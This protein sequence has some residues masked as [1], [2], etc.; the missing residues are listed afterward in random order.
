M[1][2]LIDEVARQLLLLDA[3]EA[4]YPLHLA[5]NVGDRGI[6]LD[7]QQLQKQSCLDP[8]HPYSSSYPSVNAFTLSGTQPAIHTTQLSS[9]H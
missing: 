9:L 4:L 7:E 3:N 6:M 5:R 8:T 1:A 2:L